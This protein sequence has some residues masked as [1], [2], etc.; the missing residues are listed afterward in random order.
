MFGC[1][2]LHLLPSV[3]EEVSLVSVMMILLG[4]SASTLYRKGKLYV[5]AFVAGLMSQSLYLRLFL[6][7]EDGQ[8]R[9]CIPYY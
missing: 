5:E 2:T 1:G 9:L 4:Y 7:T 3:D 8:S 6:V